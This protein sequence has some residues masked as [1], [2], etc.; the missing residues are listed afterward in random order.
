MAR[1]R[2]AAPADAVLAI[3]VSAGTDG[4]DTAPPGRR[5]YAV[6]AVSASGVASAFVTSDEVVVEA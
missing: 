2:E 3:V 1:D 4:H 5:A 6:R